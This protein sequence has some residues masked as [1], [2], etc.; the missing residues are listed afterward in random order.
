M[1]RLHR[2]LPLLLL[3]LLAACA[4]NQPQTPF[5]ES[6]SL[7]QA[8]YPV[9]TEPPIFAARGTVEAI[10]EDAMGRPTLLI[11][12]SGDTVRE[13]TFP[14]ELAVPVGGS[15]K[16]GDPIETVV[17]RIGFTGDKADVPVYRLVSL[18]DQNGRMFAAPS[19]AGNR[20][21]RVQGNIKSLHKEANGVVSM[22]QLDTGDVIRITP[23]MARQHPIEVGEPF[24][25]NGLAVF[26]PTGSRFVFAEEIN[27]LVMRALLPPGGWGRPVYADDGSGEYYEEGYDMEGDFGFDGGMEYPPAP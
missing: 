24:T 16:A 26:L 25:A 6:P 20:Y 13:I 7:T 1:I 14:N 2:F 27:G 12:K 10:R 18:R 21:S 23:R 4:Q 8:A 19:M 5:P 22:I 17:A 3:S 11:L 9:S 15:L